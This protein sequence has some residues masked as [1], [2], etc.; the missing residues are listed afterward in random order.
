MYPYLFTPIHINQVE[1]KNRIAYP[2]LGLLYS[3]DR[4]L[5]DRYYH[6]FE[7]RAKGGA[8]IVT[9]GPVGVDFIGSGFIVL[10]IDTDDAIPGFQKLTHLI[11]SHGA[12]AWIQLFH[13]GAYSHPLLINNQQPIAPSEQFC[14][15][16]KTTPKAMTIEDI[17]QVQ[18]AFCDAAKRAQESGF[19]GVEII[20]SAG[21]LIT[22]FLSPLTNHRED[23]YGGSF[24]NR[25]RFP[26]ELISKMRQCVGS[27][28]PLTIR[29]AGNDFVSGSN[30]DMETPKIAAAYANAGIDAINVTGG[31]HESKIPQLP[32]ELPRTA[33]AYLSLNIKR[34]VKVPVMASNRISSPEDA[35]KIIRDGYAD[36]VNLGRVLIADPYWPKKASME[37]PELIRPCVA[38]SQGC[39]DQ[40][41][42]GKP[43][44]CI[45]NPQA[46]FETERKL[47]V[48]QTPKKV[49]VVGAGPAGL[50]AAI[51]ASQIGHQVSLYEKQSDIG[52][53]V[54]LAGAPPG[55]QELWQFIRYYRAMLH[56]LK[57]ELHLNTLVDVECIQRLQPE[58][59]IIAEGASPVS[60]PIQGITHPSI[61]SAW[62][63]LKN[64]PLLHGNV[65]II[66]GGSVGLETALFVAAK[67]TLSP[68][69]LY[70]LFSYDAEP[71]DRLQELMF[72][73]SCRVTVFELTPK[74]GKDIG[75]ST[76]WII[77]QKLARYGVEI[78][79]QAKVTTIQAGVIS[80]ETDGQP[81]T[82]TVDH[83]ILASGVSSVK[84]ITNAIQQLNIPYTCIGDCVQPSNIGK[85]IHDGYM[86]AMNI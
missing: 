33:Y 48:T 47:S 43:V 35:E 75:R 72:R 82:K 25:L 68:E 29:M 45:A 28:Y 55:K 61:L 30:T 66:G 36:M 59:I 86:A 71:H 37:H 77:M 32:M 57:I 74:A 9:V 26:L 22:Q 15:Y 81:L 3:Y 4:K 39:S 83:V 34:H 5:N 10:G 7:E 18:H 19:D 20:A 12:K 17:H 6:F 16:S 70:F 78:I 80:Y 40:V 62:H 64:N 44:F 42:S 65:A 63:V 50:E 69:S 11:K 46:G 2:A 21:Y 24:E 14:R 79:T 1:I 49:M 67:G 84:T 8:G 51:T 73:G 23:E 60:P 53:Q 85:A 76:R 52:G 41:F 54:W 56:E 58:H 38:C 13:A 27:D 31:W